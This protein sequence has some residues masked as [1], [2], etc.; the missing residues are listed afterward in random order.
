MTPHGRHRDDGVRP[1]GVP[2]ALPARLTA[3]RRGSTTNTWSCPMRRRPPSSTRSTRSWRPPGPR[4]QHLTLPHRTNNWGVGPA[5]VGLR[6]AVGRYVCFLSDDN[7]YLPDHFEPLVAALDADP[8]L[9]F[10]YS[11]CL[12]AGRTILRDA[13]PTGARIDLGQPL[14]RRSAL[15]DQSAR[16]PRL[17][18]I[19]LGLAPDRTAARRGR[20]LGA[21]RRSVVRLP[22]RT[23]SG[24]DG[25]AAVISFI[26][27]TIGR[28]SLART[29]ASI[30]LHAG[31]E[32]L[33]IGPAAADDPRATFLPCAPAG[34]WGS[35]ERMI[36]MAAAT[37]PYLAFM[38]DD[39]VYAPGARFAM[40]RAIARTPNRPV[41]FRLQ[42][43]DGRQLWDD[44]ALRVGNVSTQMILIPN[45]PKRLGTWRTNRRESDFDFLAVVPLG[46]RRVRLAARRDS[47]TAPTRP[48]DEPS[49][50]QRSAAGLADAAVVVSPRRAAARA[51]GKG[52]A[53]R[54][55]GTRHLARRLRDC[56]RARR[57]QAGAASS[58]ASTRGWPAPAIRPSARPPATW[59][60]AASRRRSA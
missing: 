40:A 39:D 42:Y 26:V 20:A 15:R 52:Q 49:R 27:P 12:Y 9:A 28:P 5:E 21:R 36:G 10:V 51:R 60:R 17:P 50:A 41:L 55:R 31:D 44:A 47:V 30:E 2:A 14:F 13:P 43:P 19:C 59:S 37:Q 54:H 25:D 45:D 32:I 7:A 22:A 34:D 57:P 33:V 35:T 1:R 24:A 3:H 38:D 8:G 4:V 23:I 16:S 29:L 58:T 6:A 11:S 46:T 48:A 53:A 18:R 56:A